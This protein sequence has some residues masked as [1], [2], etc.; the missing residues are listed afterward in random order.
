MNNLQT[1]IFFGRSGSGKGTQATLLKEYLEKNDPDH[2]VIYI[3]TGRELRNLTK[4][5]GLTSELTRK[6]M[7][8]GALMPAFIPA[9]A[10]TNILIEKYTGNEHII[11]DGIA[12]RK[13]EAVIVEGMLDFYERKDARV[14]NLD[15]TREWAFEKLKARGRA[16]DTDEDINQR[17]DWYDTE[18]IPALEFFRESKII[19][20][21]DVNGETSIEEVQKEIFEKLNVPLENE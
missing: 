16:D 17:L 4:K 13:K 8:E 3:E 5:E 20:V 1:V 6:V 2:P 11:L 9:W 21:I 10:W 7:E 19:S 14:I 18:V 12:R 15:V